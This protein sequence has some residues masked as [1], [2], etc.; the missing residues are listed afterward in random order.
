[1]S[2]P[3]TNFAFFNKAIKPPFLFNQVYD[4]NGSNE[5]S[6]NLSLYT[7][8]TFLYG[9]DIV[10]IERDPNEPE[11]ILGEFLQK[12]ISRGTP[13][14]LFLEDTEQ[15]G[16]AGDIYSK[17]GIQI[18]DECTLHCPKITFD[19]ARS[20]L[21]PKYNDL[22]YVVKSKKL[23]EIKHIEDETSPAF[24]LL[25]NRSC[26]RIDCKLYVYDHS[27]IG[28]DSSI[29]IE[30]QALD[31]IINNPAT[32]TDWNP[33]EKEVEK[34]NLPIENI[35]VSELIVDTAEKDPLLG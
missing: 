23:F 4:I 19:Q 35:K 22:I 21:F 24:Y 10:F 15:W 29:P 14:R 6:L 1:M 18:T 33:Q 30:V 3:N 5:A 11:N 20:G 8:F 2:D 17:F 28:T 26:Y 16:G 27:E 34:F 9:T 13:M 25:G 12:K 31:N 32:N 7:E